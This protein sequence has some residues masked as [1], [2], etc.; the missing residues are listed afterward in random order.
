MSNL[1]PKTFADAVAAGVVKGI[2]MYHEQTSGNLKERMTRLE[3]RMSALEKEETPKGEVGSEKDKNYQTIVDAN[4]KDGV[5]TIILQDGRTW[6][7][8][9][10][11]RRQS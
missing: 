4:I 7:C 1:D 9:L 3:S 6:S 8:Q 5:L 11:G 2:E 10:P